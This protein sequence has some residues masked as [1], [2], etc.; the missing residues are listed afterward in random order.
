MAVKLRS[1]MILLFLGLLWP[2]LA[3]ARPTT[4]VESM[5]LVEAWLTYDRLPLGARMG[6]QV[7]G[8]TP[9]LNAGG[10][11]NFY[12][13]N[14]HPQGFVIISGDDLV[15]PIIAFS[16]QGQFLA[17]AKNP[18]Y[19]LLQTDLPSRLSPVR[20]EERRA[21]LQGLTYLPQGPARQARSKWQA[22][23]QGQAPLTSKPPAQ[24]VSDIRVSPLL[25]STWGQED[26]PGAAGVRCYNYYTPSN[27]AC[28]C[29]ATAMAQLMFYHKFPTAGVGTGE[30]TIYIG[31]P[32]NSRITENRPLRGGDDQGGPYRWDLMVASPNKDT[33]EESRK[34]IGRLTYDAGL[35][36]DMWYMNEKQGGSADMRDVSQALRDVFKFAN[37]VVAGVKDES[38]YANQ[39]TINYA[40]LL[41]MI[42]PNLDARLPV[43]LGTHNNKTGDHYSGHAVVADGYG[44]I[45]STLYHHINM[46]WDGQEN[47][48]YNT[49]NLATDSGYRFISVCNYNLFPFKKDPGAKG[50]EIIS[51]R[52]LAADGKPAPGVTVTGTA[53]GKTYA[54]VTD[55][56]GIYALAQV[57][58]QTTFTL[59]AAKD[60]R[61]FNSQMVKTGFSQDSRKDQGTP[62]NLW[63]IDLVENGGNPLNLALD[64]QTLSF[65]T[66]GDAPWFAQSRTVRNGEHYAA[67]SGI[68]GGN[69]LSWV[70][71]A[72]VGPGTLSFY[73]KV[74]CNPASARLAYLLDGVEKSGMS[75]EDGWHAKSIK[76]PKGSHTV[77][78]EYY[79][80]DADG[81]I[82]TDAG[83]LA[84][85][86]Y[87]GTRR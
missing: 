30:H 82:S 54:N 10:Q 28:G 50:E 69:Q 55:T 17:S 81:E 23:L 39:V 3:G 13:V 34:A 68:I 49:P 58:S 46:G 14:L 60:G 48:W 4:A 47:I 65:T 78:W 67:Q 15:E 53:G 29:V 76:I 18:L 80:G 86:S 66:G 61:T 87:R 77:R 36:V 85:V 43:T 16:P 40:S 42:N 31:F 19:K 57:P 52:V 38:K 83:W 32:F 7:Y 71:T 5:R 26:V 2:G 45:G 41:S 25:Q 70:E 24:T 64:N 44:Y 73:W 51:G 27:I 11:V 6:K 12:A 1:L 33:S 74:S 22:L 9:Y 8:V 56:H 59:T 35:A 63:P 84:N 79:K 75:G 21:S 72:L 62:G 37:A 20:R